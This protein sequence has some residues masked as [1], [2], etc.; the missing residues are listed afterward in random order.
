M[1]CP[2]PQPL[3][4]KFW[5][6]ER[7][8]LKRDAMLIRVRTDLGIEGYAPGPAHEAAARQIKDTIRPFLLG[9]NPK[10]WHDFNF[11]GTGELSKTYS[12]VEIAVIDAAA[13]E[14]EAPLSE[15]IGGRK[16]N[17]IKLYG[18]AGM[19]MSP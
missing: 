8:I 17:S 10:S 13:Q 7:T 16:R 18:S 6:G 5:G 15:L 14:T 4:L 2:L 19:Y 1:S 11:P 3:K 12:A 9:K